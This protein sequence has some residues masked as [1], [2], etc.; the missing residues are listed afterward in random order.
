MMTSSAERGGSPTY[1]TVS[2]ITS[3]LR[4]WKVHP[5]AVG[6]EDARRLRAV[7]GQADPAHVARVV[8][9]QE[10]RRTGHLFG[11]GHAWGGA[12]RQDIARVLLAVLVGVSIAPGHSALTR[13]FRSA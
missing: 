8:G 12:V 11:R 5:V 6:V 3:S 13:I 4:H 9:N 2:A 10:Q 7:H 1:L